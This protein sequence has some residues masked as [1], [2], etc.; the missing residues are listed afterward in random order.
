MGKVF[1]G[2]INVQPEK[3]KL[4]LFY[5]RNFDGQID[6]YSW[7][8]GAIVAG[9][10]KWTMQKFKEIPKEF[11][12]KESL[13]KCWMNDRYKVLASSSPNEIFIVEG[14]ES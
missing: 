1:N 5:S 3:G 4:V 9:T 11:R 8:G 2:G 12:R 13:V 14:D 7:H 6:P 10:G